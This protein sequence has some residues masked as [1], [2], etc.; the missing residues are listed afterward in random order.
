MIELKD[1]GMDNRTSPLLVDGL[2]RLAQNAVHPSPGIVEKRRGITADVTVSIRVGSVAPF[3]VRVWKVNATTTTYYS[4]GAD[5]VAFVNPWNNYLYTREPFIIT[6]ATA[7]ASAVLTVGTHTF[8][9]GDEVHISGATGGTVG[10]EWAA[11]NGRRTITAVGASTI[12]VSVNSAL[13]GPYTAST[14]L[15]ISDH[16]RSGPTT[17]VAS[18]WGL[19]TPTGGQLSAGADGTGGVLGSGFWAGA[20]SKWDE[21]RYVESAADMCSATTY[22]SDVPCYESTKLQLLITI[23]FGLVWPSVTTASSHARYYRARILSVHPIPIVAYP[24]PAGSMRLMRLIDTR[25]A[26]GG[27][28]AGW[29]DAGGQAE[30]KLLTRTG[31]VIPLCKAAEFFDNQ[32]FHARPYDGASAYKVY[33][34]PPNC[35][36]TYAAEE[37]SVLAENQFGVQQGRGI[38][39]IPTACGP[40]TGLVA[41]GGTLLVLCEYGAWRITRTGN[42]GLYGVAPDNLWVGCVSDATIAKGPEGTYWLAHEGIVLWPPN[43]LPQVFTLPFLD[44]ADADTTFPVD[45]SGSFGAYDVNH[46]R[47]VVH[48]GTASSFGLCWSAET[49]KLAKWTFG[50]G[51]ATLV[52]MGYDWITG[53]L[54]FYSLADGTYTCKSPGAAAYKDTHATTGQ[55]ID[56]KVEAWALATAKQEQKADMT[57]RVIVHRTDVTAAQT[58]TAS[59]LGLKTTEVAG[60]T[61]TTG[62]LSWAISEYG[63]KVFNGATQRGRVFR[64]ILN[65]TDAKPIQIRALQ[66]GTREEIQKADFVPA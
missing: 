12:T 35:P 48:V 61:A 20:V 22:G 7:A 64:V 13:F 28:A 40:V 11:L 2:T 52:G 49:R 57:C 47:Y 1:F 37:N 30:S 19:S 16:I 15:A 34:G 39:P 4:F 46:R 43:G 44:P 9:N 18:A 56:F 23:R 65:T 17:Y 29:T 32:W 21:P 8:V 59:V 45:L 41:Q 51:L 6:G 14:G 3:K 53:E 62:T 33:V 66:I 27:T 26:T 31:T 42:L 55:T 10:T 5:A 38:I 54:M 50:S 58:L 60:G 25:A 36:E 24:T 63:P